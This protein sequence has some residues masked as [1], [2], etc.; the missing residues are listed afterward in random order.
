VVGELRMDLSEII[1]QLGDL[2]SAIAGLGVKLDAI[3][4]AQAAL[5]QEQQAMTAELD[6]LQA[7]VTQEDTVIDSAVALL[8]GLGAQ[9]KALA[10]DPAALTALAN[11]FIMPPFRRLLPPPRRFPRFHPSHRPKP[12]LA[13]VSAVFR[14]VSRYRPVRMPNRRNPASGFGLDGGTLGNRERSGRRGRRTCRTSIPSLACLRSS[15][16]Q[17]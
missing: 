15:G 9:I 12:R 6:A 5:Q 10:N 13:R 7:A 17:C 1:T 16:S 14:S 4:A 3:I 2:Y 11:A 8:N